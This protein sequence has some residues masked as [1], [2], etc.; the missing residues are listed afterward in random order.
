MADSL[1]ESYFGTENLSNDEPEYDSRRANPFERKRTTRV[2][3]KPIEEATDTF[4]SGFGA[5]LTSE[6]PISSDWIISFYQ[7]AFARLL[8]DF[9]FV[10]VEKPLPITKLETRK[11]GQAQSLFH[12]DDGASYSTRRYYKMTLLTGSTD[13]HSVKREVPLWVVDSEAYKP[14]LCATIDEARKAKE[15][16]EKCQIALSK[17][18]ELLDANPAALNKI[19]ELTYGTDDKK[20]DTELFEL[21]IDLEK[22]AFL[23]LR[24]GKYIHGYELSEL[25][26]RHILTASSGLACATKVAH[27]KLL[28]DPKRVPVEGLLFP[29]IPDRTIEGDDAIERWMRE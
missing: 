4:Q 18:R 29:I 14:E 8:E 24:K 9:G 10:T 28:N 25:T 17:A 1:T 11:V 15:L 3:I 20:F 16:P 19:T 7:D 23:S 27:G 6:D 22:I 12:F 5:S 2:S 13:S 26:T 21:F